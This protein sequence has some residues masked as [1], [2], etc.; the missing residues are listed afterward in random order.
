ML[1]LIQSKD[2]LPLVDPSA[3]ETD[4]AQ[5]MDFILSALRD[6]KSKSGYGNVHVLIYAGAVYDVETVIKQ[7]TIKGLTAKKRP[8]T[9]NAKP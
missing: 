5:E 4:E 6:V 9:L 3:Q 8:D 2:L 7:K 1:P